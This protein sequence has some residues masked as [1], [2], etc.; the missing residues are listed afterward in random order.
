MKEVPVSEFERFIK[1]KNAIPDGFKLNG[2]FIQ[3]RFFVGD[4]EVARH[5]RDYLG[6]VFEIMED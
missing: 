3:T 2:S 5:S 6:D 4:K 1:K